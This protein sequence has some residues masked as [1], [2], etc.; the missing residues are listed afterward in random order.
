M[1]HRHQPTRSKDYRNTHLAG[2]I[3]DRKS[4]SSD[5]NGALSGS[6]FT[7]SSR[8]FH[9]YRSVSRKMGHFK[10]AIVRRGREY[11]RPL[12]WIETE[13]F[14]RYERVSKLADAQHAYI[15]TSVDIVLVNVLAVQCVSRPLAFEFK[16]D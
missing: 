13:C 15:R 7:D 11:D 4:V 5:E 9:L 10:L 8:V 1:H 3:Q 14:W 6:T 2:F 12:S 16:D